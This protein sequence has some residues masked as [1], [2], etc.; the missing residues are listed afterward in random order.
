MSSWHRWP[1][2]GVVAAGVGLAGLLAG[3]GCCLVALLGE[4]PALG[5]CG[6]EADL[7]S[8]GADAERVSCLFERSGPGV[9]RGVEFV[10]LTLGIG[11]DS[12]THTL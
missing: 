7:G 3:V 9:C 6:V 10:P 8:F 1:C 11:N 12:V 4:P 5:S 2:G